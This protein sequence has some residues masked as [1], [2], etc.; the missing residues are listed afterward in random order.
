MVWI[1]QL[2]GAYA[3]T[4]VSSTSPLPSEASIHAPASHAELPTLWAGHQVTFGQR[5]VPFKG[6]VQTR[7]DSFV[8]ARL[9]RDGDLLKL[10]QTACQVRFSKVAGVRVHMDAD[11]LPQ[12]R[13][14]FSGREDS[15]ELAG[16]SIV[17]WSSADIDEDGNPGMTVRVDAPI[18]SGEL[19]VANRSKTRATAT[20]EPQ[21][22]E[23]KARVRVK[24]QILGAKGACLSA[25]AKDTDENQS[26]PFAYVPVPEGSTCATLMAQGWP[27][28]A[29]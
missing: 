20:V 24:Q 7:T 5:K 4:L 18:C 13:M 28:S 29:G 27:V 21:R 16:R 11:A 2:A 14:V 25:V 9:D 19:Y 1:S 23:G 10:E 3:L 15:A 6:K 12:T 22:I 8:I 26:G 17:A